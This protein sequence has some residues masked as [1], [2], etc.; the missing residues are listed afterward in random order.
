MSHRLLAIATIGLAIALTGCKSQPDAA[1]LQSENEKLRADLDQKNAALEASE[2]ERAAADARAGDAG[3]TA[4]KGETG[5]EDAGEGATVKR[6]SEGV[7]VTLEGDVL[8]D[9]GKATL[10]DSAK[11]TLTKVASVLKE[12][13]SGKAIR[14]AG[15]TDTDPIKKSNYKSNY[16]LGFD[17]AFEVREF[18]IS[19]GVDAKTIS[20][21]S[22]G[23]D[24]PEKT[25]AQSRRVELLVVE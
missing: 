7:R 21:S 11:K 5:F 23:P 25:K 16:H 4:A 15:F 10:K 18:L 19:K 6:D 9:S 14:V 1:S 20:L 17:R 2:R 13:Y 24:R 8:F 3:K 12:K 22:Y